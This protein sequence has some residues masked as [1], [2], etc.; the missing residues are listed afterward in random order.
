MI[1]VE[2]VEE[3]IISQILHELA[4][5]GDLTLHGY[6]EKLMTNFAPP[7]MMQTMWRIPVLYEEYWDGWSVHVQR[8]GGEEVE[9]PAAVDQVALIPLTGTARVPLEVNEKREAH[10]VARATKVN[11]TLGNQ[12]VAVLANTKEAPLRIEGEDDSMTLVVH[13]VS[14]RKNAYELKQL[15]AQ[16]FWPYQPKIEIEEQE[17]KPAEKEVEVTKI[18]E[19]ER[20]RLLKAQEK[21]EIFGPMLSLL[22]EGEVKMRKKYLK[23]VADKAVQQKEPYVFKNGLL[24]KGVRDGAGEPILVVCLPDEGKKGAKGPDGKTRTLT[25]RKYVMHHEHFAPVGAHVGYPKLAD[26][27]KKRFYWPQMDTDAQKFVAGCRICKAVKGIPAGSVSWRSERYTAPMRAL[28]IDLVGPIKPTTRSGNNMVLTVIDMFTLWLWLCPISGKSA[29]TVAWALLQ[30]CYMDIAG[31]PVILRSDRGG[32]F[33]N[34]LLRE[35]NRLVGTTSVF[36]SSYHPRAQSLIEGSHKRLSEILAALVSE[37]PEDWET[38]LCFIRWAW[39]TTPKTALSNYSPYEVITGLRPRTA[40]ASIMEDVN[41]EEIETKEYVEELRR[42][43]TEIYDKVKKAQEVRAEEAQA[44]VQRGARELQVGEMV[45]LRRPPDAVLRAQG[46][47][48]ET[49][50]GVSRRLVPKAE[51]SPYVVI[52]RF[53][54]AYVLGDPNTKEEVKA[55]KQPVAA[56]RL[57]PLTANELKKDTRPRSRWK[58]LEKQ[59]LSKV[60]AWMAVFESL[61]RMRRWKTRC[62]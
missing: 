7:K 35:L 11:L 46:L 33:T 42:S 22:V 40:L 53:G 31:F 13:R 34:E 55:F 17:T 38:K 60:W 23:E 20:W 2:K 47:D 54:N 48:D 41:C 10:L 6:G 8:Q 36:G 52:R 27:L 25:W 32:E 14:M 28:Q 37:N 30:A 49:V 51:I 50:R 5:H 9:L 29:E 61:L 15:R 19:I 26:V 57:V 16:S 1:K 56:E 18:L 24:R 62:G 12:K 21:D 3:S 43:L 4:N 39:N 59:E 58:L 45:L 44:H